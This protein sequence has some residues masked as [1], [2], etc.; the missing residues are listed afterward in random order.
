MRKPPSVKN[1]MLLDDDPKLC[2]RIDR[3][4]TENKYNVLHPSTERQIKGLLET[5]NVHLIIH[6]CHRT[7][8]FGAIC[9]KI[10]REYQQV[11]ILHLSTTDG[12]KWHKFTTSPINDSI[13]HLLPDHVLLKKV[14]RLVYMSALQK[15]TTVAEA[16]L[17]EMKALDEFLRHVPIE[18]LIGKAL[19]FIGT[20]FEAQ[21]V[22]WVGLG[23]FD[24]DS[25]RHQRTVSKALMELDTVLFDPDLICWKP[26][27]LEVL[28]H[29][30][31]QALPR[32]SENNDA[33]GDCKLVKIGTVTHQLHGI[34]PIVN[35]DNSAQLGYFIVH[36]PRRW[37]Q[38]LNMNSSL[39]KSLSRIVSISQQYYSVKKLTYIDDVTCLYNQR[40][41]YKVLDRE[42]ERA[43]RNG[44]VF[45]VLFIDVDYFKKI[46]DNRGHL[47][48]SKL[49][50]ELAE[51]FKKNIRDIDFAFRYGGDEYM[52]V[53]VGATS[54]QAWAIGERIRKEVKNHAFR[55][56]D[57]DIELT[58]SV[59]VASYPEH[60]LNRE[61][62]IRMADEAMY[63]G[64]NK[65]RNIV[66]IAS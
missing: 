22:F 66:Y 65:S 63:Y 26:T 4:L 18:K 8:S 64:K 9:E 39:Q 59:G 42:I 54:L 36:N 19:E 48:G 60:A 23:E 52:L 50:S 13:R 21:N 2:G 28:E 30:F 24:F 55:I 29:I 20:R 40:F 32:F 33:V 51:V 31:K 46:N 12:N 25:R 41:L 5:D 1:I 14:R 49:L 11:P 43:Q 27:N 56:E 53:L 16:E 61:D 47:I 35:P 6:S 38:Y 3:I 15:R 62:I 37:H 34:V 45:S 10:Q 58:I 57:K 7:N 17:E 44:D